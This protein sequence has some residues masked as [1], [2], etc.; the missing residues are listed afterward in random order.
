MNKIE[1]AIVNDVI[2][3]HDL[4]EEIAVRMVRSVIE[5][6][7]KGHNMGRPDIPENHAGTES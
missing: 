4:P 6:G 7:P 2:T 1:R 5:Y 3:R